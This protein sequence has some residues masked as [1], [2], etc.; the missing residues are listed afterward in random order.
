MKS[1]YIYLYSD[2]CAGWQ[3]GG[4]YDSL[5]SSA[6]RDGVGVF[7]LPDGGMF[8]EVREDEQVLPVVDADFEDEEEEDDEEDDEE[9]DDEE[10]D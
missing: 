3:K 8:V 1:R 5:P 9:E 10:E 6:V 2:G 7:V 4:V